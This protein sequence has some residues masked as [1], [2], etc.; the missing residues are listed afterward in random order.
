MN[1]KK[2]LYAFSLELNVDIGFAPVYVTQQLLSI[3][4]FSK[5]L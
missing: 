5:N 3:N 1:Y 2:E 4:L